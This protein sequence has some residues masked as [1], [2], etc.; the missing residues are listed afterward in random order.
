MTEHI[1]NSEYVRPT[2]PYS[3]LELD[4]L[5][6]KLH[7]ELRLSDVCA[8]HPKC[9]HFYATK[10][11]GKKYNQITS[12]NGTDMGNCSVCWKIKNMENID[13]QNKAK[14]VVY[15]YKESF[16]N[17]LKPSSYNYNMYDI[18]NVYYRWLY[19]NDK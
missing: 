19:S 1:L 9:N 5:H 3:N 13:L 8:K 12:S 15:C 14:S 4:Y 2:R 18:E 17:N 11:G 16:R 6:N 10:Q 7:S